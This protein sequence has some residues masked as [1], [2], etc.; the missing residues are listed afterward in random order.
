MA[1]LDTIAARV[2]FARQLSGFSARELSALAG[3]GSKTHVALIEDGER[4]DPQSSTVAKIAEALGVDAAWLLTG[5]GK[6]PTEKTIRA[7]S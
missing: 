3:L 4:P 7:A 2:R 1:K 5:T 6:A